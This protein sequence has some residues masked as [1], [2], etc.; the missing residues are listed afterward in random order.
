MWSFGG[1]VAFIEAA[2]VL[3]DPAVDRFLREW[4]LALEGFGPDKKRREKWSNN[5]GACC[6]LAYY[7]RRTGDKRALEWL[8]RRLKGF[9]SNIPKTA[10]RVDLPA[11]VMATTLPAYTPNDGYGWV[12]CT[13]SFWYIGIP[14]WQGALR[15]QAGQ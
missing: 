4:T 6:L 7:Y 8:R 3:G 10:P 2:D 13:S 9:H 5:M 11:H 12:Y 14:A 1:H 15:A